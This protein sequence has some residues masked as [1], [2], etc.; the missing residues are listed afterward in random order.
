M[1]SLSVS[2]TSRLPGSNPVL[3]QRVLDARRQ[4]AL[5]RVPRRDVDAHRDRLAV[6]RR[7]PLAEPAGLG[8]PEALDLGDQARLLGQRDELERRH[9]LPAAPPA[10][11]RLD[12]GEPPV[13]EVDDRLQ[14]HLDLV[15]LE[16]PVEGADHLD[17]VG[18]GLAQARVEELQPPASALL[19][20]VHRD[21]RVADEVGRGVRVAARQR[22]ADAAADVHL[23]ARHRERLGERREDAPR[24]DL[25]AAGVAVAADRR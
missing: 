23:A 25:R 19:G 16:R 14:Q 17:A 15:Q 2:S 9:E 22:D 10:Q 21:V 5:Q 7:E 6:Q 13:A 24:D 1:R 18:R 4:V 11:Q 12:A 8:Q 3:A 20:H